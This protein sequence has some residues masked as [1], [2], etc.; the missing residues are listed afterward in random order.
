MDAG[1]ARQPVMLRMD[2]V[3]ERW[4]AP[5]PRS[6]ALFHDA[7]APGMIDRAG[8]LLSDGASGACSVQIPRLSGA[9]LASASG[10]CPMGPAAH[11][12][13]MCE[14]RGARIAVTGRRPSTRRP[15]DL[16]A[17]QADLDLLDWFSA[18]HR[19]SGRWPGDGCKACLEWLRMWRS[20]IAMSSSSAACRTVVDIGARIVPCLTATSAP[21]R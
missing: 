6:E 2:K 13:I 8:A 3:R 4:A 21:R 20:R 11:I 19:T 1:A 7:L 10:P 17:W 12:A 16:D 18:R 14:V 15:D 9:D 5:L